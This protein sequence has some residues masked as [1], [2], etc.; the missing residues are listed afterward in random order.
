MTHPSGGAKLTYVKKIL[1][2]LAALSLILAGCTH[3]QP[4]VDFWTARIVWQQSENTVIPTMIFFVIASDPDGSEDL[5]ELRLYNDAEGLL[6][7][8]TSADWIKIEDSGK[9]WLGSKQV[10]MP[11]GENFPAGQ[12]RA[13]ILDKAGSQGGKVFGFEPPADSR[14]RFPSLEV[15]DDTYKVVSDYPDN[16]LLCYHSDGTYRNLVKL[17]QK[18][19]SVTALRLATDVFSF[20]LWADDPANTIS[21]LTK[22]VNVH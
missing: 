13:V 21:A 12:Y 11:Q 8:W 1:R 3:A 20:A 10:R 19:G 17:E 6:W 7:R 4:S 14:Y 15:K 18:S 22:Q 2:Y 9:T 16:Y 5:E